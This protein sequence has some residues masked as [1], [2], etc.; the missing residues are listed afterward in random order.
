MNPN[1]M[2]LPKVPL[3]V[4]GCARFSHARVESLVVKS[5]SWFI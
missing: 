3:W 5:R 2:I 1:H 4:L